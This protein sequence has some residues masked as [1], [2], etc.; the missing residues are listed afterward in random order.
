MHE[1]RRAFSLIRVGRL[2]PA[3]A[4]AITAT[5]RLNYEYHDDLQLVNSVGILFR[6]HEGLGL[7]HKLLFWCSSTC[8]FTELYA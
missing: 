6:A 2:V 8:V 1:S 5:F 3:K 4:F 7:A